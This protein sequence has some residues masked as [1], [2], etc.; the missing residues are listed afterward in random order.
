MDAV[1]L[2]DGRCK[3][4]VSVLERAAAPGQERSFA[5]VMIRA[6]FGKYKGSWLTHRLLPADSPFLGEG[7]LNPV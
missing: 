5:F 1:D 4:E 2:P 6:P 3:V 7:R